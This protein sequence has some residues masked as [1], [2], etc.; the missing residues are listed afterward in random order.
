M[1]YLQQIRALSPDGVYRKP[2]RAAHI[3]LADKVRYHDGKRT[4]RPQWSGQAYPVT[5][6][7]GEYLALRYGTGTI[8]R[9]R[10]E[11]K[12]A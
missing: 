10:E 9:K 8:Y 2:I 11:L 4:V 6:A 3:R 1:T 12:A 7:Q 5:G